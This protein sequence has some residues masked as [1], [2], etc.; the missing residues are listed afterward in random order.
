MPR[1]FRSLFYAPNPESIPASAIEAIRS[2]NSTFLRMHYN[3]IP[4]N[5]TGVHYKYNFPL[6]LLAHAI[7]HGIL[8]GILHDTLRGIFHGILRAYTPCINIKFNPT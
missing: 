6:A 1:V 2:D 8:H 4:A 3:T 7:S 5:I